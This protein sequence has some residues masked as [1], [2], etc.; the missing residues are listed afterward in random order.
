MTQITIDQA[1]QLALQHHQ[2]GRLQQ[3]EHLYRQILAQVPGHAPAMHHLGLIAHQA[4][5]N[6]IAVDLIRQAITLMPSDADARF[7]LG[8]AL[9]SSG[10]LD[11]AIA[12]YRQ[13]IAL[14][15][16]Y[17]EAHNNLGIA[18][19]D[20]GQV[21]E[22]IAAYHQAIA[23]RPSFAEAHN[24]LGIALKSIGSLDEAIAAYRQAISLRPGYAE[25]NNNLGIALKNKG[26]LDEAIAAYRQAIVVRPSFAEALSNLGA[27]LA[28]KGMLDEAVAACDQSIALRPGYA[29]AFSNRGNALVT[30]G[31]LDDAIAAYRRAI[32][33]GPGF[34]EAHSNLGNALTD[35]GLLDE[36][37]VAYHQA[38]ALR[39]QNAEFHSNLGHAL[40][41]KGLLDEA[42]AAYHQVIGLRPDSAEAHAALG[43]ALK[44]KGLLDEAIAAYL[45]AVALRPSVA[46]AHSNLGNA[47]S[48]FG[49]FDDAIAAYRRALAINPSLPEVHSNLGN[50]LRDKGLL[51]DA[52]TSY[53]Q[54]IALN[55]ILP[56]AYSNLGNALKDKGQVDEAIAAFRQAI[57]LRPNFTEAHSNLLYTLHYLATYDASFIAEEHRRWDRVHAE[58]LRKFIEPHG[59]DRSPERRLRIG[60]VSPDFKQHAVAPMV[61][62]LLACHDRENFQVFC[63]A[64]VHKPDGMT[65]R[66]RAQADQWRSTVGRP[67]EQLAGLIRQDQI[68]I[69]VDLA[70]HTA[71]SRLLVFAR[72]PAP[73]QITHLGYPNTTGLSTM[74]YR[75]TDAH[76]D[77]PGL[78]DTLHSEQLIRLPQTNWIYQPP[79]NSPAPDHL[80]VDG[81]ITFGCFNTLAK[82]SEP[83]LVLWGQILHALPDCRL[84]LKALGLSSQGTGQRIRDRLATEGIDQERVEL[85]GWE[86]TPGG[87]LAAYNRVDIA[88]DPYPYH[89]TTT[90]LEALWMGVPVITL[91]GQTHVSRVGVSLL[92]NMGLADLIAASPQQYFKIAVA[93]ASDQSRLRSLHSTL[94]QR[95]EQSPLIDAPRYARNIEAAYRQIW[96]NWCATPSRL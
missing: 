34:A 65:E 39:P 64:Q 62:P 77:P 76:A 41:K 66:F 12:A 44:D 83:M 88:L 24:N 18:L 6:D 15:P 13:A 71:G 51:D 19:K 38:I 22:A 1:M 17:A 36:A 82:I 52:I 32:A 73:I 49:L 87:H 2:A 78:S 43:K 91:A 42:I 84:L 89:G 55:P 80:A 69:L 74:D 5:Q 31:L 40:R 21:D 61:L 50:A 68:D 7:N 45:Q 47:L 23:L 4:G 25:A 81:S 56:E 35:R 96:R 16:S 60:Y 93:L 14:R 30:K 92:T 95:M 67:D 85:R 27:A 46:E 94:R 58:P 20:K 70:G 33:L 53:G 86:P 48:D 26:S 72:K 10:R 9:A 54:A 59:N 11:E 57:D 8:V 75:M 37:I 63:Y 28:D 90:T 79:E 3:A 29:E